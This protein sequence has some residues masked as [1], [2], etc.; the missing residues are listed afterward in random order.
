M[1]TSFSSKRVTAGSRDKRQAGQTAEQAEAGVID[2]GALLRTLWRGRLFI[3]ATMIAGLLLGGYFAYA[4]ATPI[5]RSEVVVMLN[6]R[7]QQVVNLDSVVGGLGRDLSV[8]NTEVEV[9]RSRDLL[10]KVVD[11]LDLMSDPEFNTRLRTPSRLMQAKATVNGLIGRGAPVAVVPDNVSRAKLER[12][13]V[14][15][16]LRRVVSVRNV[17][18]SLVFQVTIA[19]E[20]A[21]KSTL[22]A[23]TLV[24]LYIDNQLEVKFD[25]TE[26]AASWLSDRVTELQE[27]LEVAE[28]RAQEF[29]TSIDLVSPE[30]LEAA[31]RQLKDLRGRTTDTES[32]LQAADGRL[33]AI[34]AADTP[35][36]QAEATN[37]ARLLNMLPNIGET[38]VMTRFDQRAQTLEL[39]AQ[40]EVVRLDNQLDVLTTSLGEF[41]ARVQKQNSDLI[42]LQQL[43]REAEASRLLYEH[44]L[45]RLKE[46]SA[47]QGIQQADS[48]VLSSAVIPVVPS[49]PRKTFIMAVYAL[50]GIVAGAALLLVREA[51]SDSFR[52]TQELESVTGYPV[53]G[54]VPRIPPRKRKGVL[55]YFSEKPTSAAA[56]A[57]RNLR[58]SV[59]LSNIDQP[60]Q[61][62][63]VS[64]SIP[65][66]G[67]TTMSLTLAH[68]LA[69]MG[70]RVLL[71]EGDVRRRVMSSYF[72]TPAPKEG[73]ISVLTGK[74]DL[75][76]VIVPIPGAGVDVL[77]GEETRANA[78]DI[79][80]SE[81]FADLVAQ[82]RQLYDHII[83][84]TP[85]VMVVPDAR[86]IAQHADACLLV[87]RWDSTSR[88]LVSEALNMFES[89]NVQV[90]GL[91]LNNID[92]RGQKRYGNGYGYGRYGRGYY[93]S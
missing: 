40:Q 53:V 48:R 51:L 92:Q 34:L 20:A 86:I 43:T 55:D 19:S 79:F 24:D 52:S 60:P 70:R 22:I 81:R 62:I 23:D 78:A 10:G 37:D 93:A 15:D 26:Q 36:E 2:L 88:G 13:L 27:E 63:M 71:I 74:V 65:G 28:T 75:A 80:A 68:N 4:V 57:V 11:R 87:V 7:D 12:Q 91:V 32:R 85:P 5:Y 38:D 33:Q 90:N 8:V 89:V 77:F 41:E 64:S 84:D 56:E 3:F 67:K 73:M 35:A 25:A 9:L 66:E 18:D 44:F 14:I 72:D 83:I 76:N 16:K 29:S 30:G 82:V 42:T 61:V 49:E 21:Q 69:E 47:Q 59:L 46:T 50:F 17:P 31:E 6:S 1:N 39:Q 45:A 54:E 58:T